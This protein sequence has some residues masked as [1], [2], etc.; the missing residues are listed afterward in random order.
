MSPQL[1]AARIRLIKL[2][3]IQL[4]WNRTLPAWK[5]Y[6]PGKIFG[7]VSPE[8]WLRGETDVT[9]LST[10]FGWVKHTDLLPNYTIQML[11]KIQLEDGN[12]ITV[13]KYWLQTNLLREGFNPKKDV[14]LLF[15]KCRVAIHGYK[16]YVAL[17]PNVEFKD[18]YGVGKGKWLDEQLS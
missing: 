17:P 7:Q 10:L 2:T 16:D 3:G 5:L 4:D 1:T 13:Q 14:D 18:K 15:D 9:I 6:K 8:N 12:F 11:D